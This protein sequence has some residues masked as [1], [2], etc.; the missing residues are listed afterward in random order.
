MLTIRQNLLE[1]IHGGTPD[2]F[3]NQ[4]EFLK[5]IKNPSGLHSRR[6]KRGEM[7]VPNS[8]G[9][10]H[11]WPAH[12]VSAFPVHT[13][14]KVVIKDITHWQDYVHA[15]SLKFS[16][17]E[18]EPFIQQAEEVD[19][20]QYFAAP[21]IAPGL[22]EQCHHLG[23][24]QQTLLNFYDE[25]EHMKDLIQY[26][27]DY[28]LE[29]AEALC[30]HLHP[31]ALFHHDDWGS[32]V[33]TFLSPAMFEEFYLDGYKQIYG[34]YKNHGV[35]LIVHHSDSYAATLVPYMI[36]MGIDIWQG[37]MSTNDIPTLI[38]KYGGKI[39]FMGGIDS[40]KVDY[41]GWSCEVIDREVRKACDANG[42]LY[43]I[44][45][46]S[47]GLAVSTFPGVYEA[48]SESIAAYSK[49]V[50]PPSM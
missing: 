14:D 47:I 19:R 28:E 12:V 9:I 17:A 1:T 7:D 48:V 49:E 33:S 35:E 3:V 20:S 16:E 43:Y 39:S 32:Q 42:K 44:P 46:T 41:E 31:D 2:R 6:P 27:V 13:P 8:W 45:N 29:L 36:E 18:W 23:E 30:S 26:L 24:I 50:F 37:V 15:P 25:P 21:M 4:Y 38:K 5:L 40:A 34:Y 11:S 10:F 22:F